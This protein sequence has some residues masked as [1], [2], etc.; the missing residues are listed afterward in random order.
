MPFV[1]L[2]HEAAQSFT[3]AVTERQQSMR[4]LIASDKTE[5][6]IGFCY[7]FQSFLSQNEIGLL[8]V[9]H[10]HLLAQ[11]G[12][13]TWSFSTMNEPLHAARAAP[14]PASSCF[15]RH[16]IAD[17]RILRLYQPSWWLHITQMLPAAYTPPLPWATAAPDTL[18]MMRRE[19]AEAA[20][21]HERYFIQM[22]IRH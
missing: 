16:F 6:D 15:R 4:F 7:M 22:M 18:L 11:A 13:I 14:F 19:I 8:Q 12:Y 9:S 2:K 17:T 3:M 21:I 10:I 5:S 20:K 1:R